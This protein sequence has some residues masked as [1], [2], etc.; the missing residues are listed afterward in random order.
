MCHMLTIHTGPP[1]FAEVKNE[2]KYCKLENQIRMINRRVTYTI[3][4]NEA[5]SCLPVSQNS[6][7]TFQHL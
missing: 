7:P 3:V 4:L 1:I 6:Y 2:I 5:F